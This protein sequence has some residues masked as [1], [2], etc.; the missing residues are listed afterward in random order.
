MRQTFETWAERHLAVPRW[1]VSTLYFLFAALG[2]AALIIG[3]PTIE[4]TTPEGWVGIWGVVVTATATVC[5]LTSLRERFEV[6][7][8]WAALLLVAFLDSYTIWAWVLVS[9][10]GQQAVNRGAFAIVLTIMAFIPTIRLAYMLARVGRT[11]RLRQ[12]RGEKAT[13]VVLL[14]V[15]LL[16]AQRAEPQPTI[17]LSWVPGALAL[18]GVLVMA[19]VGLRNN[20]RDRDA[21]RI[22]MAPPSW[23]DVYA[24]IDRLEKVQRLQTG[25][26]NAV[27]DQWPEGTP[28][29]QFD[30]ETLALIK[31]L[32]DTLVPEKWR[33]VRGR[34]RP[35]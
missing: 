26:L 8:R 29:P 22:D 33:R 34:P 5:A 7:E 30:S 19:A 24:R 14:L 25:M 18:L 23:P 28:P 4:L 13:G 15:T 21:R 6:I 27:A 11:P 12:H 9:Y 32:D 10:G 1:I 3:V 16:G 2:V 31:E 20:R 17:D 35:A